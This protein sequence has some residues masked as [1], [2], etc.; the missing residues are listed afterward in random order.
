MAQ[1]RY[2]SRAFGCEDGVA[3]PQ[4]EGIRKFRTHSKYSKAAHSSRKLADIYY[5][6]TGRKRYK[7]NRNLKQS[8]CQ[9]KSFLVRNVLNFELHAHIM[10]IDLF[11][12]AASEGISC[13]LRSSLCR[14]HEVLP[15]G[16]IPNGKHQR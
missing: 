3:T 2:G 15:E 7:G 4:R 12:Q 8:Q 13:W 1:P 9:T 11:L 5:D 16:K 14:C 6:K 10:Y